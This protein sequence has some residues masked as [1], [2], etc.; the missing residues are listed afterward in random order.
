MDPDKIQGNIQRPYGQNEPEQSDKIDP[1]KFKRVMKVE[2][3]DESQKRNKRNLKKEEEEGDEETEGKVETPP[4]SSNAFSEFMSDKDD[5]QNVLDSE[6]G[7]VRYRSAPDESE[8]FVA[9]QPGSINTEGVE[10]DEEPSP[11][12]LESQAQQSQPPPQSQA[13]SQGQTPQAPQAQTG[14]QQGSGAPP[15]S[16]EGG[17]SPQF[18]EGDFQE[19]PY[20]PQT[21]IPSHSTSDQSVPTDQSTSKAQTPQQAEEKPK[22]KEGEKSSK[23]E[24]DSSLLA[25]QPKMSDLM[26]KGKKKTAQKPSAEIKTLPEGMKT[27]DE[28]QKGDELSGL[29]K[30]SGKDE[31]PQGK[32]DLSKE[33]LPKA[34]ISPEVMPKGEK[35]EMEGLQTPGSVKGEKI[36]EKDQR[37]ETVSKTPA[38]TFR[39]M[40][41]QEIRKER[42]E[43]GADQSAAGLEGIGAPPAKAGAEGESGK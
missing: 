5:L 16:E 41:P 31:T 27:P 43:K 25:S 24:E 33:G 26:P 3:T 28:K 1:E 9:P 2:D 15:P 40:T 42:L 20:P 12:M 6:S 34:A 38:V 11:S 30:V 22:D 39:R 4:P 14:G 19:Q 32:V 10:L 23:K 7:G 18:Y 21:G 36:E 35:A 13:P 29:G 17:I 8:S 37:G